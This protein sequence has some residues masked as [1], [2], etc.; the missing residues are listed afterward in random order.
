MQNIE[1]R[2]FNFFVH[3]KV[4]GPRTNPIR[5]KATIREKK[6]EQAAMP[7][8]KLHLKMDNG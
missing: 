1:R 6:Q 8:S 4:F 7:M 2:F 3:A 5:R